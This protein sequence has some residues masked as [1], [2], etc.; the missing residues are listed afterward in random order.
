MKTNDWVYFITYGATLTLLAPV[1]GYWMAK[2]LNGQPGFL[3]R[4]LSPLEKSIYRLTGIQPDKEM[5]WRTYLLSLL[6]FNGLGFLFVF[7]LQITQRHLPLNPQHLP[8][9]P[10][11]LAFNTAVSFTTN[12]NWQAYSGE[13]TLSYLVQMAGLEVQNFLSAA[14]GIAVMLAL[15]RSLIRHSSEVIGN[16]WADV[17]RTTLYVLLPM[18]LLLSLV[19]VQQGAVQSFRPNA[20]ARTIDGSEQVIPLGPVASQVAIKQLGTNGG[21]YFG[22]NSAHPFENP[23]P[24]TNFLEMLAIMLLPAALIFTFGKMIG[25]KKHAWMIYGVM[26]LMLLAGITAAYWADWRMEMQLPGIAMEGREYRFDRA[27]SV[28]W[29]VLTTAVSNGSVNAMHGSMA[30]VTGLVQLFNMMIGEVIFGGV[31]CGMYGMMLYILLTVFIAGLMVGRT[32]EYLGKRIDR[33]TIVWAS[34]GLLLPSAVILEGTAL[35]CLSPA[36]LASHLNHGPRGFSEI[37]YAWTSS[38]AN[39]GSAMAGI[40][41]ATNFYAIGLGMAMLL[42]RF[43]VI[44]PVLAIAGHL[45]QGKSIPPSA[46]TLPTDSLTFSLVLTAVIMIVGG[47][48]F[49]PALSLGPLI[50]HLLLATGRLF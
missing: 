2:V 19:L 48:T 30:P 17:T 47:L 20:V 40:N 21:G 31:G 1:L 43:G 49:F 41:A 38:S 5:H 29:S 34:I 18:S 14:T 15:A 12:T 36:A 50:E 24:L 46:G 42:G 7:L 11:W 8:N 32:P 23:T 25:N 10:G 35:S 37:L 28:L 6:A 4:I 13:T 22:T 39:N 26:M 16:F 44:V 27:S 3:G 9:V 33:Y 45:A